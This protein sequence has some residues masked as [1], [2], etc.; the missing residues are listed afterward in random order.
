MYQL[1]GV[2]VSIRGCPITAALNLRGILTVN[3]LRFLVINFTLYSLFYSISI[4]VLSI[5]NKVLLVYKPIILKNSL[6]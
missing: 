2:R 6:L 1:G 5:K 3:Y 4:K